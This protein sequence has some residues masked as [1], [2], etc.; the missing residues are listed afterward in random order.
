MLRTRSR[1]TAALIAALLLS[2]CSS[3]KGGDFDPEADAGQIYRKAE[4]AL[5]LGNYGFATENYEFLM[6]VYPFSEYAKQGQLDLSNAYYR[7]E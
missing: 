3:N 2:A 6:A 4:R 5:D 7:N 1:L